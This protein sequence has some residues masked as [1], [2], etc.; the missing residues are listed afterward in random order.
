MKVNW[1]EIPA[2]DLTRAI[3]FYS[4]VFGIKLEAKE[5]GSKT[6]A[7]LPQG[8]EDFAG[9]ISSDPDLTPST[10]G[11]AMFFYGGPRLD[12]TLARIEPAGGK[13]L[14]P[15][16]SIGQGLGSFALFLDSEGNKVGLS[17]KE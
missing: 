11:I 10:N 4:H 14:M 3:A 8:Q 7:F 17:S 5:F 6:L 12:E 1:F 2:R 15:R 13:V 16:T 9:A